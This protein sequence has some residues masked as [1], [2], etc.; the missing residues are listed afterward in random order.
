[1]E[2]SVLNDGPIPPSA[3]SYEESVLPLP[4]E[5]T[6]LEGLMPTEES[7][8]PDGLISTCTKKSTS[9]DGLLS[10]K[11]S[12][13]ESNNGAHC[14]VDNDIVC[15]KSGVDSLENKDVFINGPILQTK[16][17]MQTDEMNLLVDAST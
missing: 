4:T 15:S 10:N 17:P 7:M 11:E 14:L 5:S 2:Q 16:E 8:S 3:L 13:V 12:V 6:S 9:P 1:M